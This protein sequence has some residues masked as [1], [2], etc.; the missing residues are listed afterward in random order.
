VFGVELI[1]GR[2]PVNQVAATLEQQGQNMTLDRLP[3]AS[4]ASWDETKVCLPDTRKAYLDTLESSVRRRGSTAEIMTLTGVV[5]SGKSTIMHTFAQL[6]AAKNILASSFFFD[7]AVEGRNNLSTLFTTIAVDLC[8]FNQGLATQI[9]AALNKDRGLCS[10]TPSRQFE[11]L[12]FK[13]LA[14]YQSDEPLV[15]L[16]DAVDE[17]INSQD[18]KTS[19][20]LEILR[21]RTPALPAAVRFVITY[22]SQPSIDSFF[23][24]QPHVHSSVIDTRG[25]DNLVDISLF[26]RHELA[27]VAQRGS[28]GGDWPGGQ[29]VE[30]LTEKAE[31]LFQWAA[32]VCG[33]LNRC[34]SP[35][36]EL[37]LLITSPGLSSASPEVKMDQLYKAILDSYRW[38]DS[39]FSNG[40]NLVMGT[41]VAAKT[42]LSPSAMHS[43]HRLSSVPIDTILHQISSFTT[44]WSIDNPSQ[45]VQILHQSL[46]EYLTSRAALSS[47]TE[48]YF[49]SEKR[50]SQEL[51]LPCLNILNQQLDGATPGTGYIRG[52]PTFEIPKF[53]RHRI[54]EELLYA[55]QFV[56]DHLVDCE[57][58]VSAALTMALRT[59]VS[60]NLEQWME[61]VSVYGRYQGIRRVLDWIQVR[62]EIVSKV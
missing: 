36:R 15:I 52:S 33:Y 53:G 32:M 55:S 10:A 44:G 18:N 60:V 31:G 22:R 4:Q 28:L 56:V 34:I 42:P 43:L 8:G 62:L 25:K 5:G 40:F 61:V 1:I 54:S 58:P 47:D 7:Q 6:C 38:D 39:V 20:L 51:A 45:P 12:I 37:K 27:R 30:R 59:F 17:G 23:R 35:D 19:V 11:E 9:V 48:R 21:D 29:L 16:I 3:Y 41:L 2:Q 50:W 14:T 13:P 49:L 24:D 26:F 57:A 46:R